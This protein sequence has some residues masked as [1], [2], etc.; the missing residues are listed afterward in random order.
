MRKIER[1][2]KQCEECQRD[3]FVLPSQIK[4]GKG[5]FCSISCKA[6]IVA[7]WN[8]GQPR[9]W[10]GVTHHSEESR[11]KIGEAS[12]GRWLGSKNPNWQ[13]GIDVSSERNKIMKTL[14][15]KLWRQTV[16]E[17]DNWTCQECLV[18]GGNLEADHIKPWSFY[19]ELRYEIDNGRTLCVSCHRQTNTYGTKVFSTERMTI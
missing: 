2:K 10:K 1:I 19:P 12:K 6:S 14:R 13:G 8:K 7:G 5:R 17:R 9:T 3:I 16:F 4:K 15:Y 18:R 11:K